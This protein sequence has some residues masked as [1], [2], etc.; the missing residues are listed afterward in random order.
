MRH[1]LIIDGNAVYEVDDECMACREEKGKGM[2]NTGTGKSRIWEEFP[3][4]CVKRKG[5]GRPFA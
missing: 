4:K 1:K 2:G 3:G 5:N